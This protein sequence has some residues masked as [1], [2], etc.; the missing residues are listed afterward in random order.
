MVN[1]VFNLR[2]ESIK[3]K[4]TLGWIIPELFSPGRAHPLWNCG[5]PRQTQ[6]A[7]IRLKLLV[8]RYGLGM[9][10]LKYNPKANKVCPM[11]SSGSEDLHHIFFHCPET[12]DIHNLQTLYEDNSLRS[13][14]TQAEIIS[15][16][17]NGVAYHQDIGV[18]LTT[19]KP[20]IL[21]SEESH[22][23]GNTISNKIC[24]QFHV[25]RKKAMEL[26]AC[27]D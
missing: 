16:I 13:P 14:C 22:F 26:L 21:L 1:K 17:L 9:D 8:G 10:R 25:K 19:K 5:S 3:D 12:N 18:N 11:C 27:I 15:A 2:I 24:I 23:Q 4:A 6:G 7:S 20:F